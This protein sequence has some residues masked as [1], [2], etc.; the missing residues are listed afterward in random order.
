MD[1]EYEKIRMQENDLL[2]NER[3]LRRSRV[4]AVVLAT[5][6]I[7]LPAFVEAV[8]P[9]SGTSS[10]HTDQTRLSGFALF[11]AALGYK[12]HLQINHIDSIKMYRQKLAE[13]KEKLAAT[14]RRP[15]EE[16]SCLSP[17]NPP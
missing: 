16:Y 5:L 6:F 13:L 4:G 12:Y 3:S 8:S 14:T 15:P 10:T 1:M 9:V 11:I 7:L 2:N 17:P